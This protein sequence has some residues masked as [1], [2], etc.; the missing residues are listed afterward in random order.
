MRDRLTATTF[1]PLAHFI[2]KPVRHLDNPPRRIACRDRARQYHRTVRCG[3]K[4]T[5]FF[6][7]ERGRCGN[8]GGLIHYAQ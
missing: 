6:C 7:F 5:S 3:S 2:P 8:G 1:A 4:A